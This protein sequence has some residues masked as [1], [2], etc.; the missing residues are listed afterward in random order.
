MKEIFCAKFGFKNEKKIQYNFLEKSSRKFFFT[1]FFSISE[2]KFF[3]SQDE[4]TNDFP[5]GKSL[6]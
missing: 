3:W 1:F 2:K 5:R 4:M 6:R